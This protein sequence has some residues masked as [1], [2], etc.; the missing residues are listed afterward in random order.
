MRKTYVGD[1]GDDPIECS[2]GLEIDIGDGVYLGHRSVCNFDWINRSYYWT[3]NRLD[4]GYLVHC[5][6]NIVPNG[7][8]RWLMGLSVGV[9]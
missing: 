8:N 5:L 7:L 9:V 3:G 1:A 4:I 2:K 6:L